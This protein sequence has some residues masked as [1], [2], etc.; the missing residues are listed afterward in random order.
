MS[1]RRSREQLD[2]IPFEQPTAES[3]SDSSS[4]EDNEPID[5]HAPI[6]LSSHLITPPLSSSSTPLNE[7]KEATSAATANTPPKPQI[8]WWDQAAYTTFAWSVLVES[9]GISRVQTAFLMA[10]PAVHQALQAYDDRYL[11]PLLATYAAARVAPRVPKPSS[12]ELVARV[13]PVGRSAYH[14]P[15]VRA[16][17]ARYFAEAATRAETDPRCRGGARDLH[18][19]LAAWRVLQWLQTDE[20]VALGLGE[21]YVEERMP[22]NWGTAVA[23]VGVLLKYLYDFAGEVRATS[24]T[25]S[26]TNEEEKER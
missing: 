2:P 7:V 24:T 25:T 18:V 13:L 9:L 8:N 22:H 20:A 14:E 21:L 17:W 4:K 6:P 12:D 19:S 16:L 5:R 10:A 23:V 3:S 1:S 11:Q 15:P 26:N